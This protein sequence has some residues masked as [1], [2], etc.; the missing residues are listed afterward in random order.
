MNDSITTA[1]TGGGPTTESRRFR[2]HDNLLISVMRE[3]AGSVEKAVLEGAMNSIDAGSTRCDVTVQPFSLSITDDGRG[4]TER[5]EIEDFFEEFGHPHKEG[6]AKFGKFRM[7]RGQIFNFG[8]NVW[9]TGVFRMEVDLDTKGLDY[10]LTSGLE[11]VNGCAIDVTL[12]EGLGPREIAGI[13][14]ELAKMLKYVE[15][16]VFVNG[17]QVNTPPDESKFPQSNADAYVRLTDG[18]TLAVY[19]QG[20]F[21]KNFGKWEFGCAGVVI[22]KGKLPV[23]FARNDVLRRHPDWQRIQKHIDQRAVERVKVK[24]KLSDG[25]R[26]NAIRRV[27][28]GELPP[29]EAYKMHL[30]VDTAGRTWS[31]ATMKQRQFPQFSAS[32]GGDPLGGQLTAAGQCIVLDS[33][34]LALFECPPG[35]VFTRFDFFGWY[36]TAPE[37]VAYGEAKA[38]MTGKVVPVAPHLWTPREREWLAVLSQM[39][40]YICTTYKERR[41]LRIGTGAEFEA[42][43]DGSSHITFTR[44]FLAGLRLTKYDAAN[45]PDLFR[46]GLLL[47]DMYC[48]RVGETKGNTEE[49]YRDFY[50]RAEKVAGAV[51]YVTKMLAPAAYKK[52][53]ER[54]K[55]EAVQARKREGLAEVLESDIEVEQLAAEA[56]AEN[57]REFDAEAEAAEA[58]GEPGAVEAPGPDGDGLLM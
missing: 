43:T 20:V 5:R 57:D 17:V 9:R 8:K 53:Q 23:N 13:K 3:Q 24:N 12:Y 40:Y 56:E 58:D 14:S 42:Q 30:F 45:T 31:A 22:S 36:G 51:R 46:A 25:E 29:R 34:V 38:G 44:E 18:E 6:D 35:E 27:L 19:N 39:G 52:L 15:V 10:D 47:L 49:F 16:P 28:A 32:Y 33:E 7:G 21:V 54:A 50:E 11:A 2:A 4:I 26:I 55:R 1:A 37:W 41:Q 48:R